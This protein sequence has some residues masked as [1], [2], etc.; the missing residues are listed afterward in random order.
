MWTKLL[1]AGRNRFQVWRVE[2]REEPAMS[3]RKELE[4]QD[5]PIEADKTALK[6]SDGQPIAEA[7]SKKLADDIADRLNEQAYREEQ[8][9]WSA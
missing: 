9:C 7:K 2:R 3:E 4:P 8:D 1:T 6:T 5:F